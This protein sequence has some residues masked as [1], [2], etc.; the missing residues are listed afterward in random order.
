MK[1][2]DYD[3]IQKAME[4]TEREAFD[5]YLDLNSGEVVVLSSEIIGMAQDILGSAY[6]DDS[7]DFDDVEPDEVPEIPE[8]MEDEIELALDVLMHEEEKYIR[9]PERSPQHAYNSM[10]AYAETL[11][12]DKL[13]TDLLATL[14]GPGSFR[15]FKDLLD[16]HP[17][18]KKKWYTFNA[19]ETKKEIAAWISSIQI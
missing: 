13:R 4:D 10:K 19:A 15:A 2:T 9:I 17:K 6:D 16:P 3:G 8:W 12:D 5:Y 11:E 1:N 14:D 7:D 18:L